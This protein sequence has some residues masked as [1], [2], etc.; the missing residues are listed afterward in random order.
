MPQTGTF[1]QPPIL[2][3]GRSFRLSS[4]LLQKILKTNLGFWGRLLTAKGP[5]WVVILG[6]LPAVFNVYRAQSVEPRDAWSGDSGLG[7]P[8]LGP[9]RDWVGWGSNPFPINTQNLI[10]GGNFR[11]PSTQRSPK[12][13]VATLCLAIVASLFTPGKTLAQKDASYAEHSDAFMPNWLRWDSSEAGR[14]ALHHSS[15][16]G[17]RGLLM[18]LGEDPTISIPPAEISSDIAAGPTPPTS[19]TPCPAN[20]TQFNKEPVGGDP[21]APFLGQVQPYPKRVNSIDFAPGA[22]KNGGDFFIGAI[23]DPRGSFGG[24]G[25]SSS[26]VVWHDIDAVSGTPGCNANDESG[27]PDFIDFNSVTVSGFSDPRVVYD[28]I[29]KRF[30]LADIHLGSS[31]SGSENAVGIF[32]TTPALLESTACAGAK[33]GKTKNNACFTLLANP[34]SSSFNITAATGAELGQ[35]DATTDSAGN[36]YVGLSAKALAPGTFF[37]DMTQCQE[38][39]NTCT[40]L[41]G[42]AFTSTPIQGFKINVVGSHVFVAYT[43]GSAPIE[44]LNVVQ[45]TPNFPSAPS[46]GSATTVTTFT[47]LVTIPGQI[48][49]PHSIPGLTGLG[50]TLV[51]TI[52]S[53]AGSLF[54]TPYKNMECGHPQFQVFTSTN[55]GATWS[56]FVVPPEPGIQYFSEPF[57]DAGGDIGVTFLSTGKDTTAQ[58]FSLNL[59]S[60]PPSLGTPTFTQLTPKAIDPSGDFSSGGTFWDA[61][62]NSPARGGVLYSLFDSTNFKG[63]DGSDTGMN[64]ETDAVIRLTFP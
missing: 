19:V 44:T 6:P 47:P 20:G 49:T 50:S 24:M 54:T 31:S 37:L 26:V 63:N 55:A 25:G 51:T 57:M 9:C 33:E 7:V 11:M 64:K 2:Q 12:A 41:G 10:S 53:C 43:Q 48:F 32:S 5:D 27:L 1:L 61:P 28:P 34:F 30:F 18:S 4:Q 52:D 14:R 35:V 42:V 62:V 3:S 46:C 17:A 40:P 58:S 38:S 29:Q 59:M 39:S 8:A 36:V 45:C 15:H 60:I 56:P 22:G 13:N 16:T 23:T 21:L